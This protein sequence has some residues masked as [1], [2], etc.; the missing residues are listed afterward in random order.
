MGDDIICAELIVKIMR[1]L[2]SYVNIIT[3]INHKEWN[4]SSVVI[5][6]QLPMTSC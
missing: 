1:K 3:G 2:I 5:R 4:L 6:D